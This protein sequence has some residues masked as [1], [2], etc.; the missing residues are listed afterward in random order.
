L[1]Y[2]IKQRTD[3]EIG[4]YVF[5]SVD[6][7]YQHKFAN[8]VNNIDVD[9]KYVPGFGISNITDEIDYNVHLT[10]DCFTGTVLIINLKKSKPN[11]IIFTNSPRFML[12]VQDKHEKYKSTLGLLF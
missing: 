7:D 4:G 9:I 6:L 1:L 3:S 12:H 10:T 2:K 8:D 11:L 5:R